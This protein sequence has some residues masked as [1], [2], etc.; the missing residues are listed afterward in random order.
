[1]ETLV[2]HPQN[3]AELGL[4]KEMLKK[5][6]IKATVVSEPLE[7]KQLKLAMLAHSKKFFI[8]NSD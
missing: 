7:H 6:S 5:M 8:K 1:M 3:K 2:I 4:L